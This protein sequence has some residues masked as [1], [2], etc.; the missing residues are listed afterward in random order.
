[1]PKDGVEN[2]RIKKA[3]L[4]FEDHGILTCSLQIEGEHWE[5][6]FGSYCTGASIS[7][8]PTS[9]LG[10]E[11]IRRIL[12]TLDVDEWGNLPGTVLR[13]K[14]EKGLIVAI[15]HIFKN[16]WFN[17]SMELKHLFEE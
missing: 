1:M 16:Q 15:G 2:G 12:L 10:W 5:Q 8:E 17:P 9:V 7:R 11:I 6:S 3:F 14:R 4:G 13:L